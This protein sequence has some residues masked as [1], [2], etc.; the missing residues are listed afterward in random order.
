[1]E[2]VEFL[3]G[4]SS[5]IASDSVN[6]SVCV[7]RNVCKTSRGIRS[8]TIADLCDVKT[9]CSESATSCR[10]IFYLVFLISC[11]SSSC[12]PLFLFLLLLTLPLFILI[13]FSHLPHCHLGPPSKLSSSPP[14]SLS[15]QSLS[16]PQI[17]LV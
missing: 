15:H 8:R 6:S 13:Y 5:A 17:A 4:P 16:P 12:F 11:P 7:P 14:R 9:G 3:L 10:P 1:M 2:T